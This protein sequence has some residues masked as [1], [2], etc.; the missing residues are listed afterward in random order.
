MKSIRV[1]AALLTAFW[2]STAVLAQVT[3]EDVETLKRRGRRA[4]QIGNIAVYD[5]WDT[6]YTTGSIAQLSVRGAHVEY[7]TTTD[8]VV[9][10]TGI[11]VHT[12]PEIVAVRPPTMY[13]H[14]LLSTGAAV[15][16]ADWTV[17]GYTQVGLL[18]RTEKKFA[19][20]WGIAA[21]YVQSPQAIGPVARLEILDNVAVQTGWLWNTDDAGDGFFA[22]ID[23]FGRLFEDLNLPDPADFLSGPD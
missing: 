10:P 17:S 7:T 21:Q 13:L 18:Q 1:I 3:Q 14:F 22:S 6:I 2:M 16:D 8:S 20:F 11:K 23:Y 15:S 5:S 4:L 12:T 9:T 19:R